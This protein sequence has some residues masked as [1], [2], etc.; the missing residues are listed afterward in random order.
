MKFQLAS[1]PGCLCRQFLETQHNNMHDKVLN[2]IGWR[3]IEGE[4]QHSELVW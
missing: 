1:F 4:R 2:S 3:Q